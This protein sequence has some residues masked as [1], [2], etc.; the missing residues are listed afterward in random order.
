MF[1]WIFKRR[2][3]AVCA[4]MRNAA[5]GAWRTSAWRWR[6][7][8]KIRY[9]EAFRQRRRGAASRAVRAGSSSPMGFGYGRARGP[10]RVT[11][12]RISPTRAGVTALPRLRCSFRIGKGERTEHALE[13]G[14]PGNRVPAAG[15]A[16]GG[17][18]QRGAGLFGP[19]DLRCSFRE[20]RSRQSYLPSRDGAPHRWGFNLVVLHSRQREQSGL[21]ELFPR[22]I[23]RSAVSRHAFQHPA[24]AEG[25]HRHQNVDNGAGEA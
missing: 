8:G 2:F 14:W 21:S 16:N 19:E 11:R 1:R 5:F 9:R 12:S 17:K 3:C 22:P 23:R 4:R 18:G 7:C 13:T 20:L 6:N 25:D 10:L 24:K 15:R